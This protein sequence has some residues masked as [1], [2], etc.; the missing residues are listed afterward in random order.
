MYEVRYQ[1]LQDTVKAVYDKI[2][3]D[4]LLGTMLQDKSTSS[5]AEER[6]K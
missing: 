1:S 2:K 5:H 6:I 4:E 3:Q